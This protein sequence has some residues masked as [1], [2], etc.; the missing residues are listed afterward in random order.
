MADFNKP[1][2][3][4]LKVDVLSELKAR[5]TDIASQAQPTNPPTNY[6][7]F[8]RT[9]GF[10]KT[11]SGTA[12]VALTS[13]YN[14][15]VANAQK[16]Q[17]ARTITLGNHASGN[18]SIDG[19]A[20]VSLQVTVRNASTSQTGVV[21]LNN[22]LTSTSTTQ[23]LTAAQGKALQDAK[24]PLASPAFTGSPTAPTQT[25]GV[26]NTTLATT[27]FVHTQA[28]VKDGATGAAQLPVGTEAQRPTPSAGK[29][30]FNS[31]VSKFEGYNG[32]TW[33]SIGGGATGGGNDEIFHLNKQT[34]TTDYT[35]PT[36]QNA[37]SAGI[38]TINDGVVVTISE[39]SSWTIV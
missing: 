19:S 6:I 28:V 23:A 37:M 32:T 35:I 26:N 15:V 34:V 13:V 8:D 27:G 1:D 3:A 25:L 5:D 10:W 20:D 7:W 21:Q 31:T 38:I 9:V 18:V 16:W 24:A 36:G 29:L 22:T 30:R 2:N 11:W 17:T 39:N 14:I 33:G 12:W 4:S